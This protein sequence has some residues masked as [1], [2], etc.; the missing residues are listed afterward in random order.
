MP[1]KESNEYIL[2]TH[3]EELHRLGV[4]HQVWAEEASKGWRKAG[5]TAGQTLLDLGCGPGFCTTELAYLA[6]KNG[7][8]LGVDKSEIYI[9]YLS[10][11]SKEHGLSIELQCADFDAMHLQPNYFDGIYSRWALAWV[12][13]PE[14]IVK[15]LYQSLKVGGTIVIHEYFDW[16]T[17][18][19]EPSTPAFAK[20]IAMAFK[21][22]AD[23]DGDINIG[24]RLP[25]IFLDNGFEI[26]S[27]R[28]MIK[29]AQPIDLAWH[30]PKTFFKVYLP[31]LIEMGYL[32]QEEVDAALKEI[33]D[34]ERIPSATICCPLMTEIVARKL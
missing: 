13:N 4:Q 25:G 8:V 3:Q 34:M 24:R 26:L 2:G 12:P 17:L 29:M 15:K 30:W 27:Q 7:K 11:L 1:A 20:G 33:N 23:M 16:T 9:N 32:T 5:F 6:G 10:N 28:P 22:F 19:S 31:S 21:S 18:Q 14:D